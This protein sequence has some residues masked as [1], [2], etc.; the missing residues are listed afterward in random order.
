M[1]ITIPVKMEQ[2]PLQG[3][4][5][6]VCQNTLFVSKQKSCSNYVEWQNKIDGKITGNLDAKTE[7]LARVEIEELEL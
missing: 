1:K 5:R 4:V 3:P 6:V 7:A 2:Q